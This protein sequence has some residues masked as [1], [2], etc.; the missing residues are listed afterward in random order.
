M[1]VSKIGKKLLVMLLIIAIILPCSAEV[2]ATA[3]EAFDFEEPIMVTQD[4]EEDVVPEEVEPEEVNAELEVEEEAEEVLTGRLTHEMQSAKIE[5]SIEHEG[6]DESSGTIDSDNYDDKPYQYQVANSGSTGRTTVFKLMQEGDYD[7]E[8]ALYCLNAEKSFPSAGAK[9]YKNM[10]DL[11]QETATAGSSIINSIGARNY[12]SLIWL[13]DN[14]YLRKQQP[15]E[16]VE[17]IKKAFAEELNK[18]VIPPVTVEYIMETITDDDIEIAQ[19]WAI[20]YFTNGNT[21]GL[22]ADYL[23]YYHARYS[24]LGTIYVKG[25]TTGGNWTTLTDLTG[26]GARQELINVLY[27]YLVNS[28]KTAATTTKTT[29]PSF[30][31][32]NTDLK[33]TVDGDYYKVGPF[34]VNSGT[35]TATIKLVDANGYEIER[36]KYQIKIDGENDF[37]NKNVNNIFNVNYYVYLPIE[38]NTITK[39]KM[40]IDY[41]TFETDASLWSVT[42][43]S[44]YQPVVLITRGEKPHSDSREKDIDS[45]KFDLALRKYIIKAGSTNISNRIPEVNPGTIASV[46]TAEYKHRKGPVTVKAGDTVIYEIRVYNEGTLNGTATKITDYLPTGMTLAE[47]SSINRVYGWTSSEDGRVATTEYLKDSV[48]NAYSGSGDLESLYV[49]IE[50]KIADD[51][52]ND[53]TENIILTNVAEITGYSRTDADSEPSVDP[54]TIDTKNYSGHKNNKEDLSDPQYYYKGLQDD[55]D[56][57]KVV[58]TPNQDVFDLAL[59]KFITKINGK[60]PNTSR[61][62]KVDVSKLKDGTSTNATYTHPKT[63]LE[64]KKGDIVTYKIRVY[65]EGDIDG[66]AE[67]ISDYIPAGLGYLKDYTKNI[68]NKWS[69][70]SDA[71]TMKLSQVENAT[72]N[73]KKEE[74]TGNTSLGDQVV[75]LGGGKFVSTALASSNSGNVIKAFDKS[76]NTLSYKDV[77]ITC[78]V[79]A[80]S[81]SNNNLKNIA[82]IKKDSNPE[83]KGDRDST[84]DSVEPNNYPNGEGSQDDHDFENL[85]LPAE[86]KFDLSLQKFITGL[87]N[88]K[89]DGREPTITKNS[90]GTFRYSHTTEPLKVANKDLVTYTIRVY[91]EGDIDG[92]AKEVMDD[93]PTGLKYLPD[94]NVNKEFE[95]K[96]Y[97]KNGKETTDVNQATSI[98]T[99]YLSRDNEK[100]GRSNLIEAYNDSKQTPSYRDVKVVFE[101]VETA[102][103]NKTERTIINTAEITDD[104]DKDGNPIEDKDSTPG[105]N[106]SG[107]DDID[108]ERVSVK[109]FDLALKKSLSKIIITENGKTREINA[110][111]E[112]DLLK[113]EINRKFI[114]KT[115]VKF[116]Y[117]ITVTNQGEIAGYAKELKDHIPTGLKFVKEDNKDWTEVSKDIVKTE[118]LAN[119]LLEPGKSASVSITLEWENSENNL[120]QKVNIAEISKDY[121]DKGSPDIDST[122]DNFKDGEDDQDDAPV[123]LSI[124]TGEEPVYIVL[125]TTVM[126]I[127]VT[128]IVLIKKY[129]LI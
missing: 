27:A 24:T 59:R 29:Y 41:K 61:E 20:W 64:V 49:Q 74:F 95:W 47:N 98:K 99:E 65:N 84:P 18:N 5:T 72:N 119:T 25:M 92:Y 91:N 71:K 120:G 57:E 58:I 13:I 38:G 15:S 123:I 75:V 6:G 96:M 121:N 11:K 39:V 93:I 62:P 90:D 10:G 128:G 77:E 86:K 103:P 125:S 45:K 87:N 52:A 8:D 36:S 102:L 9:E 129:V 14:M 127:L 118:A 16:K 88:D 17:F 3:E 115:T 114:D 21:D 4:V 67:E 97:D 85:T 78:V 108:Q 35:G 48:I 68:E 28:A 42:S 124:S 109:Y 53:I 23:K 2:L 117:N 55:D 12:K 80:D 79:L 66:Y 26:N 112:D 46:G 110:K 32:Q 7:F 94:N 33:C 19:Q 43:D 107:E 70:P 31:M 111:N 100:N 126:A 30:G 51:L 104:E 37:T 105:N 63:T 22:S 82:E 101:V 76:G 73:V 113:V 50:C 60:A 56:F 34:K 106:K 83:G 54:S 44:T 116:V 1:R 40:T 69:I 81:V 122:P 89:V